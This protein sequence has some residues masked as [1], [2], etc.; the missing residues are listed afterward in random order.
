MK[1]VLIFLLFFSLGFGKDGHKNRDHEFH[2][3][4][5]LGYLSL[6]NEQKEKIS[7]IVSENEK[8]LK[9]LHEKKESV[10]QKM[11]SYFLED[12][13]DQEKASKLLVELKTESIAI[14]TDM[15][16]K[17]HDVL[18]PKQR[19]LFLQYKREWEVE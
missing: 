1:I 8:K 12:N 3:P 16:K 17:M 15:F 11:K 7:K 14:E 2:M 10:E 9:L 4:R 5:D 19:E 18:K 6:D 13:F